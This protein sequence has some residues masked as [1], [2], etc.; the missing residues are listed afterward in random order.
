M[1]QVHQ[2]GLAGF[3]ALPPNVLAVELDQV[4]GAMH[5][6]CQRLMTADEVE[7]REP[8]PVANDCLAGM[9][10]PGSL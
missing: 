2:Q 4:E 10:A 7:H 8:T 6:S 9:T 1:Q 3:N 5:G